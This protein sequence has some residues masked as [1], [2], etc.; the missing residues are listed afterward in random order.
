[1]ATN[2]ISGPTRSGHRRKALLSAIAIAGITAL[3]LVGCSTS[4]TPAKLADPKKTITLS[5]WGGVP[6]EDKAVAIWN[7]LHPTIHVNFHAETGND[8]SK[9]P[10]AVDAGTGPDIA[11]ISQHDLPDYVI[12]KRVINIAK[13][14]GSTKNL[15]TPA[16][17][18]SV[19]FGDAIYGVPQD[20]GPAGF[21]YR[22]DIFK[23]Y[24]LTPPKTWDDYVADAKKLHTANPNIYLG[25]F[26]P[27]EF[28]MYY[29]TMTQAGG[30]WFG[31][32]GNAWKV[33]IND[34]GNK[35]VAALWQTLV[36]QK[37][38]KT[39]QMWTPEYWSDIDNGDIASIS[40]AAWFPA[41]LKQNAAS[42]SGKWAVAPQP[43]FAGSNTGGESGGGDTVVLKGSKHPAQAAEF[44]SW[45]NSSKASLNILVPQGG[46]FP[47]AKLGLTNASLDQPDPYFGG[48]KVFSVFKKAALISPKTQE[49]P[50]FSLVENDITDGFGKV[51]TGQETFLQVLNSTQ[52]DIV[53]KLK[54]QGLTVK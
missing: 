32:N 3:T 16:A 9:V 19:V 40:Y 38:L 46:L 39:V 27:A 7:K 35:K 47:A 50:G 14:V 52:K 26:S 45:L 8:G 49:G 44:V 12:N 10:A 21:L 33:T 13:Y 11:N 30:S 23:Q 20:S 53:A 28:G 54:A 51:A 1:M 41:L 17:W 15:Y 42:L 31:I 43:Q 4:T 36:D 2:P 22:T 37:L 6:H 25:Q 34:A 5:F 48:Q 24:G 29:Q 18:S